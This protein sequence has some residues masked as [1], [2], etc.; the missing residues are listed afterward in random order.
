ML[1]K[2]T[3][4]DMKGMMESIKEYLRSCCGV[5]RVSLAYMIREA[6]T[7]QT[8]GNYPKYATPNDEMITLDVTPT[9]RQK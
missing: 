2:V 6:I 1:P 4:A 7:V 5:M 8:H 9:P 3:K